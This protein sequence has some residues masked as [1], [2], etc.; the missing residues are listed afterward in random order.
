MEVLKTKDSYG[1]DVVDPK[2]G[3]QVRFNDFGDSSVDVAVKQYI[4]VP[5]RLGYIDRAKEVIYKTL[6][7][8]GISIPFPQCDIHMIGDDK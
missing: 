6:N 5:E 4:L 3:I 7:E 8:N 1:R 2:Y